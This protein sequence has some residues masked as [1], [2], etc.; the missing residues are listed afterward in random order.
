MDLAREVD[1]GGGGGG[2][3]ARGGAP[4]S[5]A[6]ATRKSEN[7]LLKLNIMNVKIKRDYEHRNVNFSD[8]IC[9]KVCQVLKINPKLDVTGCQYLYDRGGITV[10]IWLKDHKQAM[11]SDERVEVAP[12]FEIVSVHPIHNKEVPLMVLGLPQAVPDQVVLDYVELF[13]GKP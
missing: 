12:G 5:Y 7:D 8:G 4:P 2:G 1:P 6:G 11:S 13:G 3:G 10:E 9:E